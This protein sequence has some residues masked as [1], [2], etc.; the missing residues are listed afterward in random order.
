MRLNLIA[1]CHIRHRSDLGQIAEQPINEK[2]Q[3][4]W[5]EVPKCH[6]SLFF[7]GTFTVVCKPPQP[8]NAAR[9]PWCSDIVFSSAELL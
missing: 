9:S 5:S 2:A 1:N 8:P 3:I 6:I 4:T 7:D